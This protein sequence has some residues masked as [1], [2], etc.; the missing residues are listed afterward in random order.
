MPVWQACVW[1][2]ASSFAGSF[3]IKPRLVLS[4]RLPQDL[5]VPRGG[6]RDPSGGA[7]ELSGCR[8]VMSANRNALREFDGRQEQS[9]RPRQ[10]QDGRDF[11][12]DSSHRQRLVDGTAQR[13]SA[14]LA[15]V[16]SGPS[17]KVKVARRI[18]CCKVSRRVPG[19]SRNNDTLTGRP[20]TRRQNETRRKWRRRELGQ[21]DVALALV[22]PGLPG[23]RDKQ[24]GR[25]LHTTACSLYELRSTCKHRL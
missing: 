19:Q 21:E 13:L 24:A 9:R 14:L 2:S 6:L 22:L 8:V 11:S 23:I 4:D 15:S 17:N 20:P 12:E 1:L 7:S 16:A 25:T 10:E 5:R 3:D 18:A